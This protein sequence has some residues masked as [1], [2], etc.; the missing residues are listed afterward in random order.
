MNLKEYTDQNG[1]YQ[2]LA[3]DIGTSYAYVYQM[4][5]GIR[6]PSPKVARRIHA[7]TNRMVSLE[8]LRPDIWGDAA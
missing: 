7:E 4:A 5:N 8:E 1:G 6:N 2:R 3:D